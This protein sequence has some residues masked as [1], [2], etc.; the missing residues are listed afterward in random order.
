MIS[1][2]D[3]WDLTKMILNHDVI[4]KVLLSISRAIAVSPY[5]DELA[6]LNADC[7]SSSI[8]TGMSKAAP[9]LREQLARL[10]M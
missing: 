8:T 6:A 1:S 3:D 5:P 4:R 10:R 9:N 2:W 7:R